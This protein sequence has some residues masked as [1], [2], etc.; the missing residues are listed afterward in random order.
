MLDCMHDESHGAREMR[1]QRQAFHQLS[2]SSGEQLN[3]SKVGFL[4]LDRGTADTSARIGYAGKHRKAKAV[5]RLAFR[6]SRSKID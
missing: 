3:R 1:T 4:Y 6:L 2:A 5:H